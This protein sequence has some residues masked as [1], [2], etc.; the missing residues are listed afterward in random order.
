MDKNNVYSILIKNNFKLMDNDNPCRRI[1]WHRGYIFAFVK[2]AMSKEDKN[3]L[4]NILT[5]YTDKQWE[6]LLTRLYQN[7]HIDNT[8]LYD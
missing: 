5:I 3:I 4:K 7:G 2:F 1:I 8:G 6:N